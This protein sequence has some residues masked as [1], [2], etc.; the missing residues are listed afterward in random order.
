MPPTPKASSVEAKQ[1]EPQNGDAVSLRNRIVGLEY[2]DATTLR[3]HP[4]N[5]RVHREG[6][7]NA[8]AAAL[9]TIGIADTML[10]YQPADD[11]GMMVIDGHLR[12]EL[13]AGKTEVPVLV[14]DL[15]DDEANLLLASHDVLTTMAARDEHMLAG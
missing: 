7:R 4:K 13:L 10:V 3:E 1:E 9:E 14:L 8:L 2:V 6:Q 5:W 12:R 11:G 15:S